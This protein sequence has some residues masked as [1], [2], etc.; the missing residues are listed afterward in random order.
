MFGQNIK[1]LW[2]KQSWCCVSEFVCPV[3]GF[4][5]FLH[6]DWLRQ[7][8][9]WQ[10]PSGCYGQMEV[11]EFGRKHHLQERA[12]YAYYDVD[13]SDKSRLFRGGRD[14][15]RGAGAAAQKANRGDGVR[16]MHNAA[17][18]GGV[19]PGTVNRTDRREFDNVVNV[20]AGAALPLHDLDIKRGD[21]GYGRRVRA[22]EDTRFS[23]QRNPLQQDPN[24]LY[25]EPKVLAGVKRPQGG[26]VGRAQRPVDR[27]PKF[28]H[29]QPANPMDWALN[30]D[31]PRRP[32][33]QERANLAQAAGAPDDGG[34]RQQAEPSQ[35]ERIM[36]RRLLVEKKLG[37][38]YTQLVF[39][40]C[41][42]G[43]AKVPSL[44][45]FE[46]ASCGQNS[47]NVMRLVLRVVFLTQQS[48]VLQS[49]KQLTLLRAILTCHT[50]EQKS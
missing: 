49:W 18:P 30:E 22:A 11:S 15:S 41:E 25:Q 3:L 1:L 47:W 44:P 5:E 29:I 13:G 23:D 14:R 26:F 45:A 9:T 27:N 39:D 48:G 4:M 33:A 34:E 35:D 24:E 28:N 37:R 43:I 20:G 38:T 50:R 46:F 21:T 2:C 10:K 32:P 6:A 16:Y 19:G 36:L 12:V 17:A 40:N 42:A 7:I 31:A 8:L